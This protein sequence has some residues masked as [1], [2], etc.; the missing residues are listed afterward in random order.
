MLNKNPRLIL[1]PDSAPGYHIK[2]SFDTTHGIRHYKN[3]A[4]AP[5][6]KDVLGT[7]GTHEPL[8]LLPPTQPYAEETLRA[9][10]RETSGQQD[11]CFADTHECIADAWRASETSISA[12]DAPVVVIKIETN[13]ENEVCLSWHFL[14][15]NTEAHR[16]KR[17]HAIQGGFFKSIPISDLDCQDSCYEAAA[18]GLGAARRFVSQIAGQGSIEKILVTADEHTEGF[19]EHLQDMLLSEAGDTEIVV[20]E[21]ETVLTTAAYGENP[22]AITDRHLRA[23]G[24]H[25]QRADYKK[26]ISE[27]QA[28]KSIMPV[29]PEVL[30][31]E[32]NFKA[33][34]SEKASC[35]TGNEQILLY[36][37]L[38]EIEVD[39]T[40]IAKLY[41]KIAAA[42]PRGSYK[43]KEAILIAS[44]LD[45]NVMGII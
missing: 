19:L 33:H 10:I 44:Y 8:V 31:A 5:L 39:A 13:Y 26:A 42:Y 14:Q 1:E 29:A 7:A 30:K 12:K 20:C 23:L 22:L 16:Y 32:R 17:S 6:L 21:N 43:E 45:E 9:S 3:R 15:W 34:L 41:L 11:I 36:Q 2:R 24:T 35:T 38:V 28:V 4:E 27:L 18:P 25:L 40:E 37:H